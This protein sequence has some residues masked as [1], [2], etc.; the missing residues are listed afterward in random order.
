MN[1]V[2]YL[3]IYITNKNINLFKDDYEKVWENIQ[4]DLQIWNKQKLSFMG[5]IA[6]IKMNVLPRIM[7][8]FQIVPI[9]NKV[10]VFEKWQKILTNFVWAG[11]RAR[12]KV[13]VL[14]DL[15]ENG[16]F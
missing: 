12:I 15:Q 1:R 5:L 13:K 9:T 6:T 16:G 7:F 3:S 4:K 2:K 11:K 14:C 10:Q 8:L